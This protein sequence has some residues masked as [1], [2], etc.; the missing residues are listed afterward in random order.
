MILDTVY[1]IKIA[2]LAGLKKLA[3][4]VMLQSGHTCHEARSLYLCSENAIQIT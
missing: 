1:P 4:H 2:L 3:T